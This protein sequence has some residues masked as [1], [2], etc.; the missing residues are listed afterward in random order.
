[1][2]KTLTAL[3]FMGA[4]APAQAQQFGFIP[5]TYCGSIEEVRGLAQENFGEAVSFQGLHGD[6]FLDELFIDSDDGSYSYIRTNIKDKISCVIASGKSGEMIE[7]MLP[8]KL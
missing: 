4:C 7:V 5:L 1:M 2:K 6:I 3:A 8:P